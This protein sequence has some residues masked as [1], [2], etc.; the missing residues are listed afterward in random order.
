MRETLGPYRIIKKLGE[1][2]MG[3]VY[4]AEDPR[5]GRS[6]ALKTVRSE[7]A[8]PEAR[9]RLRREARAAASI[10]PLRLE[11]AFAEI[12]ARAKERHEVATA[13]FKHAGGERI[14]GVRIA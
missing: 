9:E 12:I 13:A 11:P 10:S 4:A 7:L 2:G 8:G 14:V 1:G 3:V 5:L 6:V